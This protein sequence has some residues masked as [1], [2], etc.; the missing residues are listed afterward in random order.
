M[1]ENI[2]PAT[3]RNYSSVVTPKK[4]M[5]NEP[6]LMPAP[7]GGGFRYAFKTTGYTVLSS[8]NV[9]SILIRADRHLD[10]NFTDEQLRTA[11]KI[12]ANVANIRGTRFKP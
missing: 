7:F 9:A 11:F 8:S 12:K 4:K 2:A 10:E 3:L 1:Q 6:R 5:R